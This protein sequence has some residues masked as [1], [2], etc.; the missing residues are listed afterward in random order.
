M[1][2][3]LIKKLFGW[4]K[5]TQLQDFVVIKPKRILPR[6]ST[7]AF[8]GV[9]IEKL[10]IIPEPSFVTVRAHDR[11]PDNSTKEHYWRHPHGHPF[12]VMGGPLG[13]PRVQY[14]EWEDY[15]AVWTD[16]PILPD[17]ELVM[18]DYS[19]TLYHVYKGPSA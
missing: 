4:A 11:L 8:G 12:E 17:Y 14:V 16:S 3:N 9:H 5:S 2:A 13:K 10:D 6:V 18:D 7:D 19:D 1:I 15:L